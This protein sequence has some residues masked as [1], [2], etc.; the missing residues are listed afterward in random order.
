V[1]KIHPIP[2]KGNIINGLTQHIDREDEMKE[3]MVT[4][5]RVRRSET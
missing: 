5:R 4:R 3:L 1:S 2:V